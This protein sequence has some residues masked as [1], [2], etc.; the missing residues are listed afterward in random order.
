MQNAKY[1]SAS[2][3]DEGRDRERRG[4]RGGEEDERQ[5]KRGMIRKY[6]KRIE[7]RVIP[8]GV[9]SAFELVFFCGH[10]IGKTKDER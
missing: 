8:F 10:K 4:G 6:K 9:R 2:A 5:G 7:M 3:P 1:I